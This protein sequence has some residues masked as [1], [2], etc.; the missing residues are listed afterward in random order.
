[1][2]SNLKNIDKKKSL[3]P[4]MVGKRLNLMK[5]LKKQF[6]FQK[7]NKK[8]IRVKKRLKYFKKDPE[9]PLGLKKCQRKSFNL[10][11]IEDKNLRIEKITE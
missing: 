1:M 2:S 9:Q 3:Q 11:K 4:E 7:L 6:N 10:K 8:N 5:R